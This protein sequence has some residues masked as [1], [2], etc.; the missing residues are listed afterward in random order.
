MRTHPGCTF[1][2]GTT[3]GERNGLHREDCPAYGMIRITV[4]TK[5]LEAIDVRY[6][7]YS[8]EAVEDGVW[9]R[10]L[11]RSGNAFRFD[12]IR[13]DYRQNQVWLVS[14]YLSAIPEN[15]ASFYLGLDRYSS[16]EG[17]YDQ[18]WAQARN[19]LDQLALPPR[20]YSSTM[21]VEPER[22]EEP[23]DA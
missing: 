4:E 17:A 15:R 19:M 18:A 5:T 13:I 21:T 9:Y 12:E 16:T 6:P 8:T 14:T 2:C 7:A 23:K 1:E 3:L 11:T 22:V 10:R 20:V